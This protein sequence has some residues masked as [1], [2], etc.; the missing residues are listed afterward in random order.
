VNAQATAGVADH[1]QGLASGLL[2]TSLQIGGAVVLAVVTAIVGSG[3]AAPKGQLLPH[4]TSALTV[5]L[6]VSVVGL[7][8]TAVRLIPRRAVVASPVDD[9]EAIYEGSAA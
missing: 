9:A 5:V 6:G 8:I 3:G 2:N 7:L 4:M 1:E